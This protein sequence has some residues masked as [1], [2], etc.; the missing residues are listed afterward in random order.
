MTS[1]SLSSIRVPRALIPYVTTDDLTLPPSA[2]SQRPC[3]STPT[4]SL[5]H[6]SQRTGCGRVARG[7]R[8]VVR[9]TAERRRRR[10]Q[11]RA[12]WCAHAAPCSQWAASC[13]PSDLLYAVA[14][15]PSAML[16]AVAA[17]PSAMLH[18]V[19]ARPGA[20]LHAVVARP[21]AML[22]AVAARPGAILHV[23]AARVPES[24]VCLGVCDRTVAWRPRTYVQRRIGLGGE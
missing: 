8:V 3:R 24:G 23:A 16:H 5:A 15:Q 9:R 13:A 10:R 6:C 11:A 2:D 20:M 12:R 18:A 21:S 1:E 19:A 14:A 22:H 7:E 4:R 17:R